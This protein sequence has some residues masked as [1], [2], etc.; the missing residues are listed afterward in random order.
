MT[1][2]Q[3]TNISYMHQYVQWSNNAHININRYWKIKVHSLM[4]IETFEAYAWG[5]TKTLQCSIL[6]YGLNLRCMPHRM[7]LYLRRTP[8][9]EICTSITFIIKVLY[10][11]APLIHLVNK[12][13]GGAVCNLETIFIFNLIRSQ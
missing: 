9:M 13:K 11:S 2:T 3:N 5:H 4:L 8:Q 7:R 12:K 6:R 1:M 10:F